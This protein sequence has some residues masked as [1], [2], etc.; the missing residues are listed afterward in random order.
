M[1]EQLQKQFQTEGHKAFLNEASVT[2]IDK[3]D[4]K[5]PEKKRKTLDANIKSNWTL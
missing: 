1:Q 3:I 2:F 5:D 4:R